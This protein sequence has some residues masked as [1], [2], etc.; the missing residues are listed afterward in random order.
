MSKDE[1]EKTSWKS[2]KTGFA[3]T[4]H[5]IL[6]NFGAAETT[7]DSKIVAEKEKLFALFK[8]MKRLNKNVDK[9]EATLKE[10]LIVQNEMSHDLL[11]LNEK[12]PATI[13]YSEALKAL[14]AERIRIEQILEDYYHDPFRLYLSQ[15][16]DIRSRL[17]ELDLRRLD[18]DR[19]FR[20]YSIKANKG[21]DATS[22]AKTENKHIKTKEAYEELSEELM[23]DMILLF[24]D[25]KELFDPAFALFIKTNAEFFYNASQNYQ[26]ASSY[27]DNINENDVVMH[28][29]VIT[30]VEQSAASKNVRSSAVFTSPKEYSASSA[31]SSTTSSPQRNRAST[32][33]TTSPTSDRYS[34][35]PQPYDPSPPPP[36]YSSTTTTTTTT[37]NRYPSPVSRDDSYTP[38][39]QPYGQ[40]PPQQYNQQASAPISLNKQSSPPLNS[41]PRAGINNPQPVNLNKPRSATMTPG[42]QSPQGGVSSNVGRPLPVPMMKKP[43]APQGKKARALYDFEAME[44]TELSF[45]TGDTLT[46]FKQNG[47]WYDA[48]LNGKKGL[49]PANYLEML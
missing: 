37:I 4:K 43:A 36:A 32:I 30:P 14:E 49:V 6:A 28:A 39:P 16:R 45:K 44:S 18:M 24:D 42:G 48:D 15:F 5:K 27:V 7:V 23:N 41:Q 47:D 8:L 35:P 34:T 13:A 21:K 33:S 26:R 17:E 29:W 40:P 20:D 9:Y 19:Y 31:G 10:I 38:P 11:S 22:L 1:K 12:D 3:R 46:L 2:I 25:R